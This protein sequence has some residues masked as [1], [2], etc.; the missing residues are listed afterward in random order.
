MPEDKNNPHGG[1]GRGAPGRK[2][3]WSG[4]GRGRTSVKPAETAYAVAQL[5]NEA[6]RYLDPDEPPVRAPAI[7]VARRLCAS[8]EGAWKRIDELEGREDYSVLYA[9]LVWDWNVVCDALEAAGASISLP[10]HTDRW[11]WTWKDAHGEANTA[12]EAVAAV[13]GKMANL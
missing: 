5:L 7:V 11:Q 1:I 12:G 4:P 8:L 3:H 6:A 9:R 13:I 2:R 10:F